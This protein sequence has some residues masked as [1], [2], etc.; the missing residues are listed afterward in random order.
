MATRFYLSETEAAA[1]APTISAEWD[2]QNVVR[3]RL[4]RVADSSTLTT[5][6][7]APDGADHL[8][9]GEAHHRQYI[10]D[11]IPAQSISGTVRLQIQG[12]EAH[13]NNNQVVALKIF[14]C[15]AD[16]ATIKE[17]LCALTAGATEFDS[18]S[19][20]KNRTVTASLTEA[21]LEADDRIVIEIGTAGTPAAS[22]GIQGHNASLRWGCNAS[23]GDLGQDETQTGTTF[24]PWLEFSQTI[25]IY[26]VALEAGTFTL[27]AP[28][29][30]IDATSVPAGGIYDLTGATAIIGRVGALAAD[31]TEYSLTGAELTAAVSQS[32]A[33]GAYAFVGAPL[34]GAI[35]AA[36]SAQA[37]LFTGLETNLIYTPG[38]AGEGYQLALDAGIYGLTGAG[39]MNPAT[40]LTNLGAYALVGAPLAIGQSVPLGVAA[41]AFT[42]VPT[43]FTRGHLLG[44]AA[45][46]Y[47]GADAAFESASRAAPG[48][49]AFTGA[50]VAFTHVPPGAANNIL[51]LEARPFA[52]TG[53]RLPIESNVRSITGV[54]VFMGAAVDLIHRLATTADRVLPIELGAYGFLSG[55]TI[56][57]SVEDSDPGLYAFVGADVSLVH[58]PGGAIDHIVINLESITLTLTGAAMASILTTPGPAGM[59]SFTGAELAPIFTPRIVVHAELVLEAGAYTF[60]GAAVM[61]TVSTLMDDGTHIL[62]AGIPL[63]TS[64]TVSIGPGL[65]GLVGAAI[66]SAVS[67]IPERGVYS[68]TGFSVDVIAG[69]APF[70][71][72][73]D[74]APGL[75]AVVGSDVV[76]IAD[77]HIDILE[78]VQAGIYAFTGAA[79]SGI[80]NISAAML[81][82]ADGYSFAGLDLEFLQAHN[83]ATSTEGGAYE[84]IA[85]IGYREDMFVEVYEFIGADVRL[86]WS[87]EITTRPPQIFMGRG[88]KVFR[89]RDHRAFRSGR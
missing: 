31:A 26:A 46:G 88:A 38:A 33:F 81:L 79:V 27:T 8:V 29:T 75:Y 5:T 80:Y 37:H 69:P 84:F 32:A 10:S 63:T 53:A 13:L 25:A 71:F 30:L 55:A 39:V 85:P 47:L 28:A 56:L 4:L 65:Y 87:G 12:F 17:T 61:R 77:P 58:S 62:V 72:T 21:T 54:W 9:A 86:R 35:E 45:Y 41:Y 22:S 42:A 83:Y 64:V 51:P 50:A 36:L 2:H 49:Y 52:L 3:R 18:T 78:P 7:Y 24:R 67:I 6:A 68:L 43:A 59:Y 70:Q 44:A 20:I 16:G 34:T 60:A 57:E 1:V 74:A 73:L 40:T 76:L 82:D 19:V 11:S 66:I 89:S 14:I 23:S 15:S 48:A